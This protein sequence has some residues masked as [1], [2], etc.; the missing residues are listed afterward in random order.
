MNGE[1]LFL[2]HR[3][4]FPPDRGDKI[5]SHH[6]LKALA[7]LAPVHVACFAET[8]ADRANEHLLAECAASYCMPTRSK[9]V[10]FAGVEAIARGLPVL[11]TAFHHPDI[12]AFVQRTQRE[13]PVRT[14][15]VFSGQMGQYVPRDWDGRLVVDMVDVDSAKFEQ[16]AQ[17]GGLMA[18]VYAREARML[19]DFEA[20]LARIAD[21]TL[22]VSEAEAELM[23]SRIPAASSAHIEV[24]GNGIDADAFDP[25]NW[26]PHEALAPGAG[27]HFVFTGQMDYVPNMTAV[28]RMAR[29]ILPEIRK[30]HTQAQF[31][32]VGRKPGS[33]VTALDGKGGVRVWGEVPAVQPFLAGADVVVVPLDLARGVQNK[34]L[35]AMAMARPVLLTPQ[36]ANGIAARDGEHFVTAGSDAELAERALAL[37]ADK[38][39]AETIGAA[40]RRIVVDTMS[41]PAM[42]A[43]LPEIVAQTRGQLRRNAA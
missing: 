24:L 6:L 41:W 33:E 38:P 39:G 37:L 2:A 15:Y 20:R 28:Q 10:P 31:H 40:A 35:E 42:L 14:I 43:G 3:L 25:A 4:P 36:A 5:R 8:T 34:V 19:R 22:L 1:I 18:G 21:R 23:R 12:A 9:P 16:Y 13:R 29:H 30:V 11:L 17:S 26:Q 27:P 32:V 7:D